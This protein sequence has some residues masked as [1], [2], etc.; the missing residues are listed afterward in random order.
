[1]AGLRLNPILGHG[2]LQSIEDTKQILREAIDH[3][4]TFPN[5]I[6]KTKM[7][8]CGKQILNGDTVH[9]IN[10]PTLREGNPN[11]DIIIDILRAVTEVPTGGHRKHRTRRNKK[12]RKHRTRKHRSR[13]H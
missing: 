8:E 11:R 3:I 13:K 4:N 7:I 12:Q 5:S 2:N 6:H 1:M 10:L 9:D